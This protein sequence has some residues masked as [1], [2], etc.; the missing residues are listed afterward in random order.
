[1]MLKDVLENYDVIKACASEKFKCDLAFGVYVSGENSRSNAYQSELEQLKKTFIENLL[2]QLTLPTQ[3]DQVIAEAEFDQAIA[4][5][6]ELLEEEVRVEYF[7]F[8]C[9]EIPG[10]TPLKNLNSYRP[11]V[12]Q[13]IEGLIE[14]ETALAV[15]PVSVDMI[16]AIKE[17]WR[18]YREYMVSVDDLDNEIVY[19]VDLKDE[20]KAFANKHGDKVSTDY[21]VGWFKRN[22]VIPY[23][24]IRE[25]SYKGATKPFWLGTKWS[26]LYKPISKTMFTL[27]S[28]C[29]TEVEI[30]TRGASL[31]PVCGEELKPCDMCV[32]CMR[33]L[34]PWGPHCLMYCGQQVSVPRFGLVTIKEMF[35]DE[36]KAEENGYTEPTYYSDPYYD[37]RGK[38]IGINRMEFAAIE[39]F[40][41]FPNATRHNNHRLYIKD[42]EESMP[43]SEL[44]YKKIFMEMQRTALEEGMAEYDEYYHLQQEYERSSYIELLKETFE[45]EGYIILENLDAEDLKCF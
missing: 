37:V 19:H 7:N 28:E 2:S 10:G 24:R 29:E 41:H 15:Q 45:M 20:I 14:E 38:S 36:R 16:Q 42:E 13:I 32:E 3:L 43:I 22:P 11:F 6:V 33:E 23:G 30:S 5:L 4:E 1:M 18:L 9:P 44:E 26:E 25:A 12:L 31:C 17:V 8:T 39:Q 35:S 34:C 40:D 21:L 27:C